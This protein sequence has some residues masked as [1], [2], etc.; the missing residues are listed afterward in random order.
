MRVPA[1]AA[2]KK[3]WGDTVFTMATHANPIS[4]REASG[5]TRLPEIGREHTMDEATRVDATG[6]PAHMRG[7]TVVSI[8]E[9]KP[10]E[11]HA[12]DLALR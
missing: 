9:S 6:Q 4:P 1:N 3:T 7:R 8:A 5:L 2:F 10:L 12:T 11:R